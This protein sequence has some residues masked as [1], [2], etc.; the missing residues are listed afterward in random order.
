MSNIILVVAATALATAAAFV[1][2]CLTAV[3]EFEEVDK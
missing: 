1:W 2:V 3:K